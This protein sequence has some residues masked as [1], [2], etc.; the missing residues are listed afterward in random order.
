[1]ETP[2]VGKYNSNSLY[3]LRDPG[4][5]QAVWEV[6]IDSP[7][8]IICLVLLKSFKVMAIISCC[9]GEFPR[10][11]LSISFT[12]Y[13]QSLILWERLHYVSLFKFSIQLFPLLIPSF[14]S[15][16][17]GWCEVFCFISS[18]STLLWG[19]TWILYGKD[20]NWNITKI[21][22]WQLYIVQHTYTHIFRHSVISYPGPIQITRDI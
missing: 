14:S 11:V 22:V 10:I 4:N 8:C 12:R 18:H 6:V 16:P 21:Y 19:I 2:E 1:M 13:S 7:L 3:L 20:K 17:N 9:G 5:I 15:L